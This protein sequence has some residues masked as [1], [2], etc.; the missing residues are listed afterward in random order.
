MLKHETLL[1]VFKQHKL[2]L[3]VRSLYFPLS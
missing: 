2:Q 1:K 3:F